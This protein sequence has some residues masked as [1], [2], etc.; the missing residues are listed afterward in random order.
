MPKNYPLSYSVDSIGT[1]ANRKITGFVMS[2]MYIV[3]NTSQNMPS[4]VPA[5][6]TKLWTLVENPMVDDLIC[7]GEVN[8]NNMT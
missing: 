7:W 1:C 5:F 4:T 2:D 6:L 3:N 8:Y